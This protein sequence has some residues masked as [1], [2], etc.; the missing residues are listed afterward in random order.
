MRPPARHRGTRRSILEFDPEGRDSRSP[1]GAARDTFDGGSAWLLHDSGS[2]RLARGDERSGLG[3]FAP[4]YGTLIPA[5]SAEIEHQADAP[6]ALVT[7]IGAGADDRTPALE[8]LAVAG[9]SDHSAIAARVTAGD[10]TSVFLIRPGRMTADMPGVSVR[11]YETDARVL[12][13]QTV[14]ETSIVLLTMPATTRHGTAGER[15][16]DALSP[17]SM[18]AWPAK[19]RPQ[20]AEPPAR[21]AQRRRGRH[22]ARTSVTIVRRFDSAERMERSRSKGTTGPRASRD[23]LA[24]ATSSEPSQ[25]PPPH[26]ADMGPNSE[27]SVS[28]TQPYAEF[29]CEL[30]QPLWGQNDEKKARQDKVLFDG[31]VRR[32]AGR[33]RMTTTIVPHGTRPHAGHPPPA[34]APPALHRP[35]R[36]RRA[37][38]ADYEPQPR[39]VYTTPI[40]FAHGEGNVL[41]QNPGK[42]GSRHVQFRIDSRW[43]RGEPADGLN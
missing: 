35:P 9:D 11:D 28:S 15:G 31:R 36:P 33:C 3:W 7:W 24:H 29:E 21:P 17:S 43:A 40:H 20:A 39:S 32:D 22:S 5:W 41:R 1:G 18:S 13:Y 27:W 30:S 12:H 26:I 4:V 23:R 16:T 42:Q 34:P 6:F 8:R 10:R 2:V 37:A 19:Y 38:G 14:P 25:A